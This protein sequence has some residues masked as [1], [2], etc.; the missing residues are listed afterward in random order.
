MAHQIPAIQRQAPRRLNGISHYMREIELR[1][2][3]VEIER[4]NKRARDRERKRERER[5]EKMY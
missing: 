2:E 1:D 4:E 5:K 3:L